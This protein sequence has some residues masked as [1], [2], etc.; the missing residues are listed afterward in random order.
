MG[1]AEQSGAPLLWWVR[2]IPSP[3]I[4][5]HPSTPGSGRQPRHGAGRCGLHAPPLVP[6]DGALHPVPRPRSGVKPRKRGGNHH[7]ARSPCGRMPG[8]GMG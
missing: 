2:P 7:P 6:H 3:G 8:E 4:R 5:A 1:G